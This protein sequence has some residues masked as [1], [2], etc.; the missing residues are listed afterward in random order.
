MNFK[1]LFLLSTIFCCSFLIC[2]HA[3]EQDYEP[4][5]TDEILQAGQDLFEEG[6]YE[7]AVKQFERI[8]K[9][10]INY[11]MAQYEKAFALYSADKKEALGQLLESLHQA[12]QMKDYPELFSLY[13]I[14]FSEKEDYARS[15]EMFQEAEKYVPD[16]NLF[17]YN[18]A[19]MYIRS[20]R[21]QKAI[22]YLKKLI[23]VNPNNASAHYLLGLIAYEDGRIVEGSLGMLGYLTVSP[24][25][26][27][28]RNAIIQ[29]NTKMGSLY[30]D[31]HS[32]SFSE[33]GDDFSEL[34]LILKNELPL[35]SKYQVK[36][37]IDDNYTRQVQAI[38]EYAA[39]HSSRE[40][41]YERYYISWLSDIARHN[42]TENYMYYTLVALEETI[43]KPL[44]SQK[45][46]IDSFLNDYLQKH[47][48]GVYA[49][50]NREHF[51]KNE[52][53][54]VYLYNG[55]PHS[56]GKVENN[57]YQGK[58]KVV[59]RSGLI[60]SELNYLDDEL[61]G[62]Q[63]Y[64]FSN[65][66]KKEEFTYSKGIKNGPFKIY[67]FNGALMVEGNYNNDKVEGPY[68]S[69][70]PNGGVFCKLFYRNG[71]Q[72]GKN[73]CYFP[74]GSKQSEYTYQ[75][76]QLEEHGIRY[77]EAG[78]VI[79]DFIFANNEYNGKGV[80][81]Y[82]G[83]KI[84]GIGNYKNGELYEGFKEYYG[85][86]TLSS[87]YF[88]E[89]EKLSRSKGFDV[90][91]N[92]KSESTFDGKGV[93][94]E[95]VYIDDSGNRF[96]IEKY[97][98]GE[99]NQVFQATQQ[100]PEFRE[101]NSKGKPLE[102]RDYNGKLLAVGGYLNGK[103]KG[104]WKFYHPNGNLNRRVSFD[105]G[106]AE[107]LQHNYDINGDLSSIEYFKESQNHGIY[108][109]YR[110]DKPYLRMYFTENSSFGPYAYFYPNGN[111][112]VEG[113]LMDGEKNYFQFHYYIN[114]KIKT[115]NLYIDNFI[116]SSK[117]Y[118]PDGSQASEF[119]FANKTGTFEIPLYN[120]SATQKIELVNGV[121]NGKETT[122]AADGKKIAE[123]S[124]ENGVLHGPFKLYSPFGNVSYEGT[125]YSGVLHG[126][127]TYYDLAGNLRLKTNYTFNKEDGTATLYYPNQ[128]LLMKYNSLEDLEHGDHF[129]Y[130]DQG[131]AVAVIYYMLDKPV[132][133]KVLSKNNEL[134]DWQ[135]ITDGTTQ[136]QS[137]YPNGKPAM[138]MTLEKGI[139]SGTLEIHN[140]NG[141][142]NYIVNYSRNKL[143]GVRALY[144]SNGKVYKKENFVNGDYMGK[145]EYFD[146]NGNLICSGEYYYDS[147]HGEFKFYENGKE[148][149]YKIYDSDELVEIRN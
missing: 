105:N 78:D 12:G 10:D 121:K 55:L 62:Y 106:M 14:Y 17:L 134:G 32:L 5:D 46:K 33:T 25:G 113:F 41:F 63:L 13:G 129:Y 22:E 31:E 20:D 2:S 147:A 124:L 23:E 141:L 8:S 27:H 117:N 7:E 140:E 94:S 53:V 73:I 51:G 75:N 82:D 49:K 18:I 64:Y 79:S 86:G 77:N 133:F 130:N 144:H 26:G 52:E 89:N 136:I 146:E 103:M 143:H 48:W 68:T 56:I 47:F 107:G 123:S 28:A 34:E 65:G 1:K 109:E 126:N 83:Q 74:N 76:G 85:N 44:T 111:R 92:Q 110:H 96:Y 3:Q 19:L 84:K 21:Q 30:S 131:K 54:M 137:F 35:S 118:N 120:G 135:E 9:T 71:M 93:I 97:K 70:H 100:S 37:T 138:K 69:Y 39:A 59:D 24:L 6:K 72:D 42:Q 122:T 127:T 29:L 58:H 88:Y 87:E 60:R 50:R 125:Y 115:E 99:L 90:A 67:Y 36:S 112:S 149:Q 45:K 61:D 98:K 116:I 38:L 57:I 101:I 80:T 114:G 81:Y 139:R 11:L 145:Q 43:G 119:D 16:S 15:E 132:K 128:Q 108:E 102:M 91:G 104:E 142:P 4:Y 95:Y 148:V 40:G 66:N